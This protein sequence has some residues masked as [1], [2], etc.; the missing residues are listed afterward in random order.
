MDIQ[1]K[2]NR[3][4]TMKFEKIEKSILASM[5]FDRGI[6]AKFCWSIRPEWF[7]MPTNREI[8]DWMIKNN[9]NDFVLLSSNLP[10]LTNHIA[11][12]NN[13]MSCSDL[14]PYIKTLRTAFERRKILEGLR[15]AEARIVDPEASNEEILACLMSDV[16]LYQ[17]E[18]RKPEILSDILPRVFDN[19]EKINRN[20]YAGIRTGISSLDEKI[21]GAVNG[22]LIIIAAR[23]SMGKSA[24][25]LQIMTNMARDNNS[26]VCFSLE[27]SKELCGSRILF[28]GAKLSLDEAMRGRLTKENLKTLGVAVNDV[29]S[30]PITIDDTPAISVQQIFSKSETIKKTKGLDVIF[31]DHIQLLSVIAKSKNRNE[32]I[33]E[34]SSSLKNMARILDVPV[35]AL[36]QMSR[37]IEK[38]KDQC[39]VLSDLRDGGSLEQDAD[40]IIFL[41]RQWMVDRKD[42]DKGK[43][44][45]IAAKNRNGQTG[46]FEMYFDEKTMLFYSIEDKIKQPDY[47]QD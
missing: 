28:S 3:D 27:M 24:L 11:E 5:F 12:I 13:E 4:C 41:H 45:I 25:A 44:K 26:V 32:Q 33:M 39:P 31:I 16:S 29:I 21:G 7:Y 42:E 20:G 35:F 1:N 15:K 19:L 8:F 14:T 9:S 6:F 36:S 10:N 47:F 38:R 37:D 40:K 2:K 22:D 30:I 46:Q 18:T 43:A 34:I 23:P 17:S